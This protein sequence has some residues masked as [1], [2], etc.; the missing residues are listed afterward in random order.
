MKIVQLSFRRFAAAQEGSFLVALFALSIV[1]L[2]ASLAHASIVVPIA[3][4]FSLNQEHGDSSSM[5]GASDATDAE[6]PHD[7]KDAEDIISRL[8]DAIVQGGSSPNGTSTNSSGGPSGGNSNLSAIDG[9]ATVHFSNSNLAGWV[10]GEQLLELP[11]PPGND[12]LRPPQ[13]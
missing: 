12:L 5:S 7:E 11:T 8:K 13:L 10:S 6:S 4:S 3:P 1:L 2:P 9:V